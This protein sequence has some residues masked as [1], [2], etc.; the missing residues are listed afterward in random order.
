M[1]ALTLV[2]LGVG[3]LLGCS[4]NSVAQNSEKNELARPRKVPP[5]LLQKAQ[6]KGTVRVIVNLNVPEW[7]SK[8]QSK[9]AELAQRQ[10]I[11]DAQKLVL[12]ELAGTRY[13][14]NR[15]F[16]TVPGLAM[17][18]GPDTLGALECSPRVLHVSE[19]AK[20]SPSL[21]ESVPLVGAP[22]AW[23]SDFDGSG[24]YVAIIDSGIDKGHSFLKINDTSIIDIEACFSINADCPDGL[25]AE[26][27]PGT[28]IY[29][30]F[31]GAPLACAHGTGLASIVASRNDTYK[32]VAPGA[33]LI[34]IRT[35]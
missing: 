18:V 22:Q 9:E 24:W 15:Q 10:K 6:T 28:G 35:A 30:T 26:S 12:G 5:E 33:R 34:S 11:A 21:A 31:T 14:I 8:K 3:I 23:S 27:G 7:T 20:L 19:D 25:T 32:G 13:K 17:E 29:C 4:V 1:K 16:E 2:V